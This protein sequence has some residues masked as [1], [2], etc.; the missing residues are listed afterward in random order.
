MHNCDSGDTHIRV[1]EHSGVGVVTSDTA[2]LRTGGAVQD[3]G[4][5]HSWRMG[6]I[7]NTSLLYPLRS[8]ETIVYN[9]TVG[10]PV[11]VTLEVLRD[12][13]TNLTDAQAWIEVTYLGVSGAPQGVSVNDRVATVIATAAD[14]DASSATWTHAM[15]NPNEQ[16]LSVTF[17]PAEVGYVVARAVLGANAIMYVDPQLVLS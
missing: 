4:T 6:G 13:V 14:Q 5:A 10:S 17:T 3:D 12:S 9:S 11:T 8:P 1:A 15:T 7:T 2:V 16:K